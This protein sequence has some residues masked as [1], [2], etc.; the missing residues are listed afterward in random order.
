MGNKV[1]EEAKEDNRFWD[2]D[3]FGESGFINND[4]EGDDIRHE[5]AK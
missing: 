5:Y 2:S 3:E 4:I 1:K